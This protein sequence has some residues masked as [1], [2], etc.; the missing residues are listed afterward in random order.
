MPGGG[1]VVRSRVLSRRALGLVIALVAGSVLL[2][3]P[4][5][6]RPTSSDP[7]PLAVAWPGAQRGTVPA[8]L[9]D[10]AAY[11]PGVFLDAR[12]SVGTAQTPDGRF[13][14]L[15]ERRPNGSV[16]EL[17]RLPAR[18]N[19]SFPAMTL[20]GDLLVWAESVGDGAARLCAVNLRDGRPLRQ[21]TAD[22]GVARFYQRQ[23]DLVV[24]D[25][26]V[27]WVAERPGDMTEVR[28]VP[29]GG[30]PVRV[31]AEAGTWQLSAWPWLVDG[32]TAAAG[33]TALKNL[34]TGARVAVS[35]T[36]R[37][38]TNCSPAWCRVVSLDSDGF[39][40]IEVMHPGG[41]ARRRIAGGDVETLLSDVALLD[42]FEV[43]AKIGATAELTGNAE[44][45]LYEMARQRTVQVSPDA[46]GVTYRGGVLW[47]STGTQD[48]FVRHTVDLRSI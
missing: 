39:T 32:V 44:V 41:D 10:G 4:A 12:T 7:V 23:Y 29:L 42:R 16:R 27:H 2:I 24:A 48:S 45:L 37:A 1:Y 36:R 26:R 21:L 22:T 35:P 25:G 8:D 33:S 40:R 28:S 14:R 20:D 18:Q 30:G 6:E 31:T 9:A 43:Y 34:V 5:A 47:W 11:N 19:P 46:N 15:L 3:A 13:L 38:V 17:R